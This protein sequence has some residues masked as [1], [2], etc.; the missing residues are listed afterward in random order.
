MSASIINVPRRTF[1][2]A[3]S[4]ASLNIKRIMKTK[5]NIKIN[6]NNVYHHYPYSDLK[7][8]SPQTGHVISIKTIRDAEPSIINVKIPSNWACSYL[9][10]LNCPCCRFDFKDVKIP[11]NWA[12]SYLLRKMREKEN[13]LV[14]L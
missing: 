4:P 1:D 8:K 2:V 14:D 11:S 5:T 6:A 12:C 7:F 10:C 3:S 9:Y 13:K